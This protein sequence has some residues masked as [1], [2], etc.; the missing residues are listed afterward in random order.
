MFRYLPILLLIF[1]LAGCASTAPE[2]PVPTPRV[3]RL[4]APAM[5]A[6]PQQADLGAEVY[7]QVCMACHGDFGQGL[8]D[9]WR[10]VWG[11]DGNCWQSKCHSPDHPPQGFEIPRTCCKAVMG[12]ETLSQFDNAQELYTYLVQTM[13]W[14]NP[15]Y[16][17]DE[18]YWQLTAY[19]MR[20]HG[21][22]PSDVIL[23]PANASVFLLRP[24]TPLPGDSR[25]II[26]FFSA[27]LAISAATF[28]FQSRLR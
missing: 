1:L 2:S 21:A 5:P 18:E 22:M 7:Y 23:S 27:I 8:T 9:E 3:D 16:L 28:Y 6:E 19:L 24:V 20:A 13:P 11:E 4:A 15:G 12:D 10:V 14:W 25:P 17:Q 26:L